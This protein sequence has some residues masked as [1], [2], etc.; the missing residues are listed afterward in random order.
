MSQNRLLLR[1]VCLPHA[2]DIELPQYA[3]DG[4]SGL[5]IRAAVPTDNSIILSPGEWAMVPTG[6]RLGFPDGYEGQ[7]RTR[8][9]IAMQHG[10]VVLNSPGTIDND[11][12]GELKVLLMNHGKSPFTI[13]RGARIAQLVIAPYASVELVKV[14]FIAPTKRQDNGF[15]STGVE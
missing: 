2:Q 13:S 5:D 12:R 14:N 11:Y 6:L 10:I 4:S 9:G 7:I 8:S 1:V 3:S 15:G